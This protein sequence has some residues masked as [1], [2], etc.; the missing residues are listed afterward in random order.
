MPYFLEKK[1][2]SGDHP[3]PKVTSISVPPGSP[4]ISCCA[5]GSVA[6]GR[7]RPK[8]SIKPV[9]DKDFK[10]DSVFKDPNYSKAELH[11]IAWIAPL[12][13]PDKRRMLAVR[14]CKNLSLR[15]SNKGRP[16]HLTTALGCSKCEGQHAI[17]WHC[18]WLIVNS[19]TI[20]Y[21]HCLNTR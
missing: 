20:A 4:G 18:R 8:F 7:W 2:A 11:S 1:S 17:P 3:R 6:L 10:A 19:E 15:A 5:P 9:G 13:A 14:P 21:H 12:S 16:W